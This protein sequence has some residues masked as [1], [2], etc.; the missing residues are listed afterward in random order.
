MLFVRSFVLQT[1]GI[2][3]L[4]AEILSHGEGSKVLLISFDGFRYDYLKKTRES[5]RST[6][7]F[8]QLRY[9]GVEAEYV[10]NNFVTDTFPNHYSIVTGYFEES[11]GI[12]SNIFYDPVLNDTFNYSTSKDSIWWNNGTTNQGAEPVWITNEKAPHPLLSKRRSGVLFWPGGQVGLHGTRA[13]YWKTYNDSLPDKTR[14]DTIINWFTDKYKPIN[15]GLLYF[16]EPDGLGH[17]VGPNS[18][19]ILDLIVELD[20]IVG[21]LIREL[22]K[23]HLFEEMNIIITSDH[24]MAE[25]D[26]KNVIE[27]DK[28]VDPSLYFLVG[29]SPVFNVRPRE[30]NYFT[31]KDKFR[32]C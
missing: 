11:H 24:G 9:G 18:D 7:N 3:N 6:T 10:K 23:A 13:S 19:K 31:F 22:E 27:L 4:F 2:L 29:E 14:V 16:S 20:D 12:V 30:G 26:S 17:K 1:F 15:L 5:G 8:D 32:I 21:Y 28:Y 25:I